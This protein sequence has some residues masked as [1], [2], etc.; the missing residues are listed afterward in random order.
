MAVFEWLHVPVAAAKLE[1]PVSV[2]IFLGIELDTVAMTLRLPQLK[3]EELRTLVE[4][5][6]GKR[7]CIKRELQSR[8]SKLQHACKVVRPGRSFLRR[9]FDLLR[10]VSKR[11][12]YV[13]LNKAFHSDLR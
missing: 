7:S 11:Q 10:G 9:M 3:L 13:C 2:I 1:G 12:H 8:V 6:L 4:E 5:W